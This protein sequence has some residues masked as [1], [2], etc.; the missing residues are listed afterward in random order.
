M[1][2]RRLK[3][4]NWIKDGKRLF[5]LENVNIA[6]IEIK[7]RYDICDSWVFIQYPNEKSVFDAGISSI[8]EAK[9]LC[10]KYRYRFWY[11]LYID[12]NSMFFEDGENMPV[13]G[14]KMECKNCKSYSI[15]IE[16][17]IIPENDEFCK[18]YNANNMIVEWKSINNK[19]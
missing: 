5:A 19:E 17:G 12:V 14:K 9:Q 7:K 10:E 2:A 16:D 13:Y 4:L 1:K 3:P 8:E 18:N 15:C 11:N 6:G